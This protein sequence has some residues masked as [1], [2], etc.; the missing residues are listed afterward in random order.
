MKQTNSTTFQ[1]TEEAV[2]D[3]DSYFAGVKP[4]V[5]RYETRVNGLVWDI[6]HHDTVMET[7]ALQSIL[8]AGIDRLVTELAAANSEFGRLGE[9]KKPGP[10]LMNQPK[11]S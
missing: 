3:L 4:G 9:Y 5:K 1:L 10:R 2:E 7:K 6:L 8:A 11:K